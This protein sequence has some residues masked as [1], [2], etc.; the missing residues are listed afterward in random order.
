M[1][2]FNMNFLLLFF[3]RLVSRLGDSIFTIGVAWYI[4]ELTGSA[5]QMGS[6]VAVMIFTMVLAGPVGGNVV[7]QFN[8]V[9][10]LYWMDFIRGFVVVTT[11]LTILSGNRTL[12]IGVLYA[13]AVISALCTAVFNPASS[14]LIPMVVSKDE[15]VKA[16]SMMAITGSITNIVGL[17]LGGALYGLI[18]PFG[19]ILLDGTSYLLSGISELFIKVNETRNRD[20]TGHKSLKDQLNIFK[21]GLGYLN[22]NRSLIYIGLFATV[23]NFSVTPTFQVY[24][25]YLIKVTLSQKIIVLTVINIISSLG[26][27]FG[28]IGMSFI[29]TYVNRIGI[30]NFLRRL[31]V[32]LSSCCRHI[33]CGI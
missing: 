29:G 32:T 18:G 21:E 22:F 23:L 26:M 27:L 2:K 12:I 15:L 5:V 6:F 17:L 9:K 30:I 28:G 3:G 20:K 24:Q 4:L 16:N 10:L 7:D 1:T 11:A 33:V 14:A 8:K 31:S 13:L 19:V 25:P